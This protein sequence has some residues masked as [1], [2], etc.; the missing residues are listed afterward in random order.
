MTGVLENFPPNSH[1]RFNYLI[2]YETLPNWMKEFWY[3]HE[4]YTY[5]LL[6]PNKDPKEIE[7]QFPVIA[8]KYK[9][10]PALKNK[11]AESAAGLHEMRQGRFLTFVVGWTKKLQ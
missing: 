8:E 9:T 4:A 10:L 7:A 3:L 5:L 6:S 1:I 11:S 2:S